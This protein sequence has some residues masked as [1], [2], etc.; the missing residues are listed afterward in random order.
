MATPEIYIRNPTDTEA[1]GPFTAQQAA[2]L[3]EAGQI[4]PETLTYDATTEQWTAIGINAS[5]AGDCTAF[6]LATQCHTR[7]VSGTRG[8]GYAGG[9]RAGV[10]AGRRSASCRDATPDS[11]TTPRAGGTACGT[12]AG[13]ATH[14]HTR[15]GSGTRG[16]GYAGGSRA[17]VR[18]GRRSA[19]GAKPSGIDNL[20]SIMSSKCRRDGGIH[21]GK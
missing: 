3:A 4:T 18:A 15:T 14:C 16:G 21:L 7:T 11:R 19:S 6:G 2:D 1:R 10:R 5:R 13:L 17:G 20:S 12:A 9:C 8:G